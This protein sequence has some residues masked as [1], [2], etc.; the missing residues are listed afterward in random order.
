MIAVYA[1]HS[2]S[3]Q[4][5]C[6]KWIRGVLENA[7]AVRMSAH[8]RSWGE[9]E[10]KAREMEQNSD[11][12][13]TIEHAVSAFLND[14]QGRRLKPTTLRQKKAFFER[15]FLPWCKEHGLCRLDQLQVS[16]LRRLRQAW[17]VNSTTA[18]RRHE[19]LRSFFAFCLANGWV[20]QN[21]TNMLKRPVAFRGRPTD[22]F[23]RREFRRIVSATVEY[24]GGRDC[25]HRASRL[26]ALVLL[27]RWSGL[28]IKDAVGLRRDCLDNRGALFLRRAKTGVPVFCTVAADG[29]FF[30]AQP[31]VG[32]SQ[33]FL[34]GAVAEIY[35]AP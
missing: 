30:A 26:R 20:A 25:R 34:F 6:P 29:R 17:D 8:T 23:N 12:R 21:P 11:G 2:T 7:D 18:G 33:L 5:R 14:E 13:I 10:R 15:Q 9:A 1:R 16:Q 3:C 22:Y 35:V 32:E 19:R 4:C 27:M 24:G 28:A 31:A